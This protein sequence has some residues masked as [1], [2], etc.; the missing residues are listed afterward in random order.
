MY[1][2]K[3]DIILNEAGFTA[4]EQRVYKIGA[5][6]GVCKSSQLISITKLPKP[7]VMAALKVLQEKG[8]CRAEPVDGRTY[9]YRMLP[10]KNLKAHFGEQI[11]TLDGLTT[12]LDEISDPLDQEQAMKEV[13]G[14][15]AVQ[16]MLELALRCKGRHW[17]I[18]S[19]HQNAL[20]AMPKS[21]TD[22][23]KKIRKERQ[24]VSETLWESA[25]KKDSLLPRDLLM[26][27]PRFVPD[28][29][30]KKIPSL[31]LSFDDSLLIIDGTNNPT[32]I[33]IDSP[34]VA[35]T[36]NLIFEMAWRSARGN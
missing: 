32:A 17:K 6:K 2:K 8:L 20:R 36:F 29:L 33:L 35:R 23:F 13:H 26:R 3:L 22:Y 1:M 30:S 7:T 19:P 28:S 11:R 14:Q 10:L 9:R 12:A 27:K 34:S 15:Q 16:D 5:N 18:I 21:Y 4:A 31:M 25:K 24:I